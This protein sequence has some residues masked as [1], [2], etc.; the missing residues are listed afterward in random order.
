MSCN[1][2]FSF[3]DSQGSP[4]FYNSVEYG[5]TNVQLAVEGYDAGDQSVD[6][7]T[8]SIDSGC[9]RVKVDPPLF[10]CGDTNSD[11]TVTVQFISDG[12]VPPTDGEYQLEFPKF[13]LDQK[14]RCTGYTLDAAVGEFVTGSATFDLVK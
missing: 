10:D 11:G 9:C 8:L 5:A 2:T 4:F 6:V 7:T 3:Q 12:N 1:Q 13:G 14:A